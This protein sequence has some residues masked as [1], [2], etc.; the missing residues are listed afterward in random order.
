MSV[1]TNVIMEV[2]S[3]Q[4]HIGL[5]DSVYLDVRMEDFYMVFLYIRLFYFLFFSLTELILVYRH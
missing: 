2:F 1:N 3:N 5:L 4:L